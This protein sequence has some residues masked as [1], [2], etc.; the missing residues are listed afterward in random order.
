VTQGPPFISFQHV[1]KAF[2]PKTIFT[3]LSIDFA[4]GETVTL[5]GASG[6]G[7][8]V[9]LK[10]LIGLIKPDAGKIVFDAAS[11]TCSRAPRS[12][13]PSRWA[14]TSPT[15]CASSSGTR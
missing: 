13:T 1:R 5:M 8:S 12:S 9:T 7:K 11:P 4:R 2:G 14:R 3:D 6:S 10:M 15:A